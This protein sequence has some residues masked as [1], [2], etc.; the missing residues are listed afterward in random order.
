MISQLRGK[1]ITKQPPQLII[2]VNGVGYEVM[3]PMSTFYHLPD[4]Q[5]TITI[6][7]HLAIREDAHLLF[8]FYQESER[9]LFRALIKVNGVGPKLAL[10]ILSGIELD[11]FVHCIQDNDTARLISIPG[12]GKK[13][14]E[15]LIIEMRDAIAKWPLLSAQLDGARSS[16]NT[17]GQQV[18]EDAVSALTSLG[19]KPV[20]AK[21]AAQKAHQP[22]INSEELIRLALKRMVD[23]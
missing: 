8:G 2:D 12:V 14:A 7:T 17:K 3:A 13:M 18:L 9:S 15:R 23:T 1:I 21:R 19:Y 4:T 22:D 5:E 20:E 16:P 11:T 6:L 10:A